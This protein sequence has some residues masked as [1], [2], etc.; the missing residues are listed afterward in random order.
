MTQEITDLDTERG[1]CVVQGVGADGRP[2]WAPV[3][4]QR[5]GETRDEFIARV[6]RVEEAANV[7]R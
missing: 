1:E 7:T 3:M 5:Q 2:V 6:R 4:S